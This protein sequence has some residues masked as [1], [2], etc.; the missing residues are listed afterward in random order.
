[1]RFSHTPLMA[2]AFSAGSAVPFDPKFVNIPP[3]RTVHRRAGNGR[4]VHRRA[5][6]GPG[7]RAHKRA[8]LKRRNV[9]RNRRNHRG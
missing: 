1:M 5:G 7:T 9:L 6:N 8:A 4:T 3:G 2:A